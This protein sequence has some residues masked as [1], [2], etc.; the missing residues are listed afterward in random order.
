MPLP[1]IAIVG[2]PNVGKSSLFNR[3]VGWRQAIVSE[4]AGTTRDRLM[5]QTDWEG[6]PFILLDT[7]GLD[8]DPAG[9]IQ[10]GVQ[11]QAQMAMNDADA[12]ILLTDVADGLTPADLA[13]AQRLRTSPKPIIL[14][15][16]KVDNDNRELNAPEF[17]QLGIGQPIP[18]SAYHNYGIHELMEQTLA[19][20][21]PYPAEDTPIPINEGFQT[22]PTPT[23]EGFQIPPPPKGEGWGGGETPNPNQP[24]KTHPTP[25]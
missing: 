13:A 18:I 23:E 1:I 20:L 17:W 22:P 8:P 12:I 6:R 4:I 9:S 19:H 25:Q 24:P 2:R 7:G 15:V 21:P 11:E 14:A 10:S 3:I 16:N 5:A